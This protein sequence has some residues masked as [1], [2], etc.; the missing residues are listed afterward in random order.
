MPKSLDSVAFYVVGEALRVRDSKA[1]EAGLHPQDLPVLPLVS[2]QWALHLGPAHLPAAFM[3][4]S[5][6]GCHA[7]VLIQRLERLQRIAKHPGDCSM[8]TSCHVPTLQSK[9]DV[10]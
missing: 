10:K 6:G 5:P 8:M 3:L 1:A 4:G 2:N 7:V 9:R